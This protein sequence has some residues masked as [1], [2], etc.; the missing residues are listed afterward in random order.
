MAAGDRR[1]ITAS[2]REA[3]HQ[4][5]YSHW[6][7]QPWCQRQI[8]RDHANLPLEY[9]GG[10]PSHLPVHLWHQVLPIAG[11]LSIQV[12]RSISNPERNMIKTV[13]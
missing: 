10:S 12:Q 11:I 8:Y 13:F 4:I 2:T 1:C 5:T 3:V 7:C 9:S 6:N